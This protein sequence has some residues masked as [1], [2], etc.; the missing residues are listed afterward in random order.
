M[1]NIVIFG[2]TSAIAEQLAR[3]YAQ[4]QDNLYLFARNQQKLEAIAQDLTVRGANRVYT[5]E[6]TANNFKQHSNYITK[7]TTTFNHIDIL[8]IAH[9]SLPNQADCEQNTKL[10]VTAIET[11]ATSIIALLTPL[12]NYMQQQQC[13]TICVLGSVAADRGKQSNYIYGA[14]KSMVTTFM[15]GLAQRLAKHNVH[16]ICPKLGFVD[17]P[18]TANFNKGLLWSQPNKIATLIY[19]R[20]KNNSTFAY[21]P[22]FWWLIMTIIKSIPAKLFNK[23]SL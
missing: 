7:I 17:T 4:Q 10:A 3:L 18:M 21:T 22:S 1:Q 6:F 20:I 8:I 13:G 16:V 15:Q 2:A 5:S 9:G 23:V 11:N 12:A 14:A 19:K